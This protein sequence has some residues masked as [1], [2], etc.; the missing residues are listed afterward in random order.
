MEDSMEDRLLGSEEYNTT[1]TNDLKTRIWTESKKI[2]RVAF[3]GMVARVTS[4]GLLVVT[5][6]F[7]GRIG[8]LEL[9]AYA[10]EQTIF[11]RFINGILIGMSSATET[12]CGQAF[13]AEQYHML[14][15]YLQ[16]SWIVDGIIATVLLPLFI[17]TAPILILIGQE[18]DISLIAGKI[19]L[20]F[21]PFIYYFVF[22]LTMQM[23]L[24]AQMKNMIVG[25]V[26][27]I[28]FAI[29]V[30]L[31]W[32]LVTKLELGINGAMGA[33]NI[34]G[35]LTV[36]GL[37]VYVFGGWCPDTWKGFT[38]A[39]FTDIL[40]VVKLSISSGIMIC[41]ELWYNSIL[42]VLA[43]YLKNATTAISAFSICLNINAWEFMIS[44]AFLGAASV[45]V[46]NELGRGNAT[47]A[48]FS[49]RVILCTSTL[50]GLV[51][52]ILC[53]VF[54]RQ[55]SYIFTTSEEVADTVSDLSPLLA[56]SILLNSI[57]PVLSGVAIGAGLQNMVAIVNLGCYYVIGIPVGF[58]LGYV[59]D[60]QVKGLWIGLLSGVAMQ[61]FI[62]SFL[63]WKTDWNEQVN[64]ASER[65]DRW[66]LDQSKDSK[67]INND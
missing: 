1:A 17:F 29:H 57:Q 43:G 58:L 22:S 11:L 39:A 62:L 37:F 50:I 32:F 38:F 67:D 4:F 25:W 56:F 48:K 6:V 18:K 55:I 9:A 36:I 13:G 65:L 26:S 5:Q 23:Y 47:A 16:R 45:R 28:C 52:F 12:L 3:P 41:L 7:L 8:E 15:I 35:W 61:T 53:L 51:F 44:L 20:W 21:I 66:L 27:A 33:V 30:P 54:D 10:I 46:S 60:L 34:S 42:L 63:I 64:K 31:S 59:A 14:G 40:P 2:W 19:S 24:Q 49:I